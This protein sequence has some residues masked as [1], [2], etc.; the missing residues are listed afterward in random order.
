MNNFI[1]RVLTGII[2]IAVFLILIFIN[3]LLLVFG[4]IAISTI[5]IY[6]MLNAFNKMNYKTKNYASYI[7]N[8]AFIIFAEYLDFK[9]MFPIFTIYIISLLI[10]IVLDVNFTFSELTTNVFIAIYITVPYAYVL[11]LKDPKW[12]L[13]AFA[14]P[15]ATDTF[16]YVFGMLFGKH[17]LI[18]RLSPKKTIEGAIGGILGGIFFT[19]AFMKLYNLEYNI[20]VYIAAIIFSIVSQIGDLFASLIKRKANIKDY[21]NILAG[22]GGIMDRFDSLLLVAPLVYILVNYLRLV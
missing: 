20:I 4:I 12:V 6:E 8:I 2:I 16:A 10:S 14:I 21:G 7:F 5:A 1:T 18:E 19:F 17:K 9:Y 15:A 11:Q 3:R 13:Y 22:H